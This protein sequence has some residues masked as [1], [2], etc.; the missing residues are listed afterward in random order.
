[1]SLRVVVLSERA[2]RGV[3]AR[4]RHRDGRNSA[5]FTKPKFFLPQAP[6]RAPSRAFRGAKRTNRADRFAPAALFA[7]ARGA[8]R[9]RGVGDF[10]HRFGEY[11]ER[12]ANF[13]SRVA[14]TS[15]ALKCRCAS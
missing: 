11:E 14:A 7:P 4:F 5:G 10:Q 12:V 9:E 6:L 13:F 3:G 2:A 1:V 8:S 15:V